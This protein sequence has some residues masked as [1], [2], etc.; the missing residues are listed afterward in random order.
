MDES[1]DEGTA[2]TNERPD[3]E[4]DTHTHESLNEQKNKKTKK[5]K[6]LTTENMS[7]RHGQG[8]GLC[9]DTEPVHNK[10]LRPKCITRSRAIGQK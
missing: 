8:V 2:R 7:V 9:F 6:G 4:R 3:K 1:L 10:A 5:I